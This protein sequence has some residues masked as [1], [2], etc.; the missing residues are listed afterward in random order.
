[1]EG[2]LGGGGPS[3]ETPEDRVHNQTPHGQVHRMQRRT[4]N[5]QPHTGI[6]RGMH[7]DK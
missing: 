3:L 6:Q 1:M 7:A 5:I 4:D 2:A